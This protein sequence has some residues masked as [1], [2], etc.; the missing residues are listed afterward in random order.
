MNANAFI[1]GERVVWHEKGTFG[2]H[3]GTV[4]RVTKTRVTVIFDSLF[5]MEIPPKTRV[6]KYTNLDYPMHAQ[7]SSL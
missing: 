1:K 7:F 3:E 4:T 2:L 5:G 6:I